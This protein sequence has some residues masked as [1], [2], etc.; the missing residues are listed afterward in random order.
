VYS[1]L[2]KLRNE[3]KEK[4][5]E[6]LHLLENHLKYLIARK[7]TKKKIYLL[8]MITRSIA[9]KMK[10]QSF[11]CLRK[12]NRCHLHFQLRKRLQRAISA[13]T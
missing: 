5:L 2:T 8:K 13:Q 9:M 12:E 6:V 7:K 11:S 1:S 4:L 3:K 10:L